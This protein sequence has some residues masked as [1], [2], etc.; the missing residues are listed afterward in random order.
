LNQSI[1][2]K[3]M[4]VLNPSKASAKVFEGFLA[5]LGLNPPVH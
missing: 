1:N 2:R 4:A 5:H 3:D